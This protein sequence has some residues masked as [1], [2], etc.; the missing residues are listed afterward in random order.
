VWVKRVGFLAAA[1]TISAVLLFGV[2]IARQFH[3]TAMMLGIDQ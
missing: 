2:Y 1:T 3:Q